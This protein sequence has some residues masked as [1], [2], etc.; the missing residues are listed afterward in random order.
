MNLLFSVNQSFLPLL[1]SCLRS[2]LKN[3]GAPAY[4]VYVLHSGL[5]PAACHTLESEFGRRAALHFVPVDERLFE[6][7]PEFKRYPRQ[8]YYRLAAPL[9]LPPELDRILYLD[10]D[11]VVINPLG[12]LYDAPFEGACFMACTNTRRLLTR[13]NQLRLGTGEDVPYIN[14]GVLMMDL[15]ALRPV[16]D[17]DQI[18]RYASERYDRL[19]LPDQDILTAL[20]GDRV[21]LMDSLLYNLSDRTLRLYNASPGNPKRDLEWVRR[22]TVIVHYF[23]RNKPWKAHY[24]GVLG[25]FY[26]E[27]A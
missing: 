14:S 12:P 5:S 9:L 26:Y 4:S 25:A 1:G 19:L 13:V 17:M 16:V 2:V 10:V 3:G 6:G 21:K 15:N 20:Y 24:R 23:G 18:R 7:F 22:H 27:F 8:I 11:T